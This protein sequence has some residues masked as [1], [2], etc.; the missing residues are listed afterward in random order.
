MIAEHRKY[1]FVYNI[2]PS[3]IN[4]SKQNNKDNKTT[5]YKKMKTTIVP[6]PEILH[7]AK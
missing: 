5:K 1:S 6:S 4:I 2:S 7:R 3:Y